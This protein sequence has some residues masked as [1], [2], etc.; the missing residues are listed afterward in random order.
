MIGKGKVELDWNDVEGAT[1][2][3]VRF[4]RPSEWVAMPTAEIGI[5]F[6]GSSATVSNLPNYGFYYFAVRPANRAGESEWSDWLQLA[7]PE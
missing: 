7:N 5:V 6:D 3:Q 2:Y 1:S 4:W